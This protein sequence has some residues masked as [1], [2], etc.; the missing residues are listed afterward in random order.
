V[1]INMRCAIFS[2]RPRRGG[3]AHRYEADRARAR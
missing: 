3:E 2:N 1:E